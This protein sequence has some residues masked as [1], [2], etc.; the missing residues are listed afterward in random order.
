[1]NYLYKEDTNRPVTTEL[2]CEILGFRRGI[3][4]VF[5]LVAQR[6]VVCYRHFETAFRSH[7][8]GS[9]CLARQVSSLTQV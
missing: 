9:R 8:Q 3:V 2:F 7:L 4:E 5:D 6:M 1:M